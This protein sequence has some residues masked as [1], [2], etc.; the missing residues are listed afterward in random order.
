MK[1]KRRR[2]RAARRRWRGPVIV[3]AALAAIGLGYLAAGRLR[4]VPR[5][6]VGRPSA[7][8]PRAAPQPPRRAPRPR[9]G[10]PVGRI[11]VVIDDL[12]RSLTEVDRL[13]ALRAPLTYSVLPFETR[14]AEVVRR[15]RAAHAEILCHL[16]LE[17][18]T[19]ADPGPG[20]IRDDFSPRRVERLTRDALVAVPGAVGVNNH[21]GSRVTADRAAMAAILD[22]VAEHGL[23]FLDSR[24]TPESVAYEMARERGL[25]TARRAVFLDGALDRLSIATEFARLLDLARRDGAA[26]AIGHPHELTLEMLEREIPKALAAGFEIVPVSYL[27]ERDERLPG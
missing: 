14:T 23:F 17:G 21:M 10:A 1:R 24:T 2:R 3:A 15:L 22:V 26:I 20:A 9:A 11:A 8:S 5:P 7:P 6:E 27:L 18:R 19:G 25:P 13:E 4:T 12:G 16:P